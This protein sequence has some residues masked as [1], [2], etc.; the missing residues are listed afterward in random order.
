MRLIEKHVIPCPTGSWYQGGLRSQARECLVSFLSTTLRSEECADGE[1]PREKLEL[2][3]PLRFPGYGIR[4]LGGY[5]MP[6]PTLS[7]PESKSSTDKEA[8]WGEKNGP[9]H[10]TRPPP[11]P[12]APPRPGQL[13][14]PYR[15][16]HS[17]ID[18]VQ[19]RGICTGHWEN[20]REARTDTLTVVSSRT[21]GSPG[22]LA[23]PW[24]ALAIYAA[25]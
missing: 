25:R 2:H 24:Q 4:G 23:F 1:K 17:G 16:Q 5:H 14:R 13:H 6:S 11:H 8:E 21:P 19:G 7:N 10:P 22:K 20:K 12:C 3:F 18:P 9:I 15:P